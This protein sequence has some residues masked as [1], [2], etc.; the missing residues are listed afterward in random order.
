MDLALALVLKI[1]PMALKMAPALALALKMAFV[2]ALVLAL[3]MALALA[4][5]VAPASPQASWR[6]LRLGECASVL[7]WCVCN[8]LWMKLDVMC[9]VAKMRARVTSRPHHWRFFPLFSDQ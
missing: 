9:S 2:L 7:A 1:M 5:A 8:N 3:K 6:R 4:L